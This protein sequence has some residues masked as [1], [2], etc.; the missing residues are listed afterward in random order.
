MLSYAVTGANRSHSGGAGIAVFREKTRSL[1]PWRSAPPNRHRGDGRIAVAADR[2]GSCR[3]A[4]GYVQGIVK[5]GQIVKARR[6]AKAG[7]LGE[8]CQVGE[9]RHVAEAPCEACRAV[10]ARLPHSPF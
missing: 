6:R 7:R 10:P 2:G 1:A 4:F 9:A 3:L 8:A 5:A